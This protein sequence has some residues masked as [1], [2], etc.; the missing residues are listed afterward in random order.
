[1]DIYNYSDYKKFVKDWVKQQT[2]S[3][4]GQ[5]SRFARHLQLSNVQ[6]SQIF[7]GDRNLNNEQSY[8][9][10]KLLELTPAETKYFQLMLQY[11][12]ASNHNYKSHLAEEMKI[13][14][15]EAILSGDTSL[16]VS[17]KIYFIIT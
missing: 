2:K 9:L 8:F 15:Q 10:A 12:L 14:K 4:R 1:M 7:Q 16:R 5:W 6:I 3:G 11:Q 13:N 17:T